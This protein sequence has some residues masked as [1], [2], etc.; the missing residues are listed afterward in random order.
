MWSTETVHG[1]IE[2][3]RQRRSIRALYAEV[4]EEAKLELLF[5]EDGGQCNRLLKQLNDATT[6]SQIES[7][8][9]H[10]IAMAARLK[11]AATEADALEHDVDDVDEEGA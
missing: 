8:R 1:A 10:F 11:A 5:N 6:K 2:R 7:L 4:I 9:P 3:V